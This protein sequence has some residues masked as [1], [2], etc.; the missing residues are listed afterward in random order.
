MAPAAPNDAHD[1]SP[2]AGRSAL[3]TGAASGIGLAIARRLASEGVRVV[4]VDLPGD[5]LDEAAHEIER[6]VPAAADLSRREEVGRL[7]A[8]TARVDILVNNAGL[9][10][11]SPIDE[12]S[13]DAWDRLLSVMLTAPFL[14][15]KGLLPGMYELGWGRVINVA[16]VHGLVTSPFKSA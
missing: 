11:V 2:L 13:E 16:S 9:Q 3:V 12:F 4:L 6:A 8:D 1:S 14:L 15:T 5:A 7:V 10:H